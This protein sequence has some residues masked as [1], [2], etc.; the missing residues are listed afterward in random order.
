MSALQAKVTT[1]LAQKRFL[2]KIFVPRPQFEPCLFID[3]LERANK[4]A[5]VKKKQAYIPFFLSN[6]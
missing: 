4:R 3:L 5:S 2:S 1:L 6:D